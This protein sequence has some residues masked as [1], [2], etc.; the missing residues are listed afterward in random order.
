MRYEMIQQIINT[1]EQANYDFSLETQNVKNNEK[2]LANNELTLS[3]HVKTM[4]YAQLSN[5]RPWEPIAQNSSTIN[6][7]FCEFN[8][9]RLKQCEA[10]DLIE[11]IKEIKCGNRQIYNQLTY[12]KDNIETLE[13][14][15]KNENGINQYFMNTDIVELVKSLS[16][17]DREYK[18]RYMG[19]ALVCEYLK[20]VGVD[21]VKP[22]SLIRRIIGR[23]GYSKKIPAG[24]WE[25]IR[26]CK[27]IGEEYKISQLTV[28]TI[29]WQ[30]CAKEKFQ[31]CT[32]DPKCERCGVTKCPN[33]KKSNN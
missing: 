8:I 7:I 15:E 6:D 19:V 22:D 20:N 27:E 3:D 5:N 14:I 23:L 4:V 29:L 16:L 13:K 30:Y 17:P 31:V 24:E 18:L 33:R 32:S 9:N 1:M 2:K 12:L 10:K 21:V 28:D 11:K 25:T 26:I